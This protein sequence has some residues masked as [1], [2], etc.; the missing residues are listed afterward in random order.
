MPTIFDLI[1]ER[2]L[3]QNELAIARAKRAPA[4]KKKVDRLKH[5]EKAIKMAEKAGQI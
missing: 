1:D 5:L 3:L 4:D 2:D